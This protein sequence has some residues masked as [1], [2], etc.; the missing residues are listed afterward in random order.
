M[1]SGLAPR[2]SGPCRRGFH[3]IIS[4][5]APGAATAVLGP[6]L[7]AGQLVVE[8]AEVEEEPEVRGR[9]QPRQAPYVARLSMQGPEA[10]PFHGWK[11]ASEQEI[12]GCLRQ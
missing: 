5:V 4:I 11:G 2:G 3:A 7:L 12:N 1:S 6:A 9:H 8:A 10:V